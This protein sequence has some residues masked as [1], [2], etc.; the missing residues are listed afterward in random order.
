MSPQALAGGT[1]TLIPVDARR[2]WDAA[3]ADM[4]HAFAHTWD[5]CH[6]MAASSGHATYL[7]SFSADGVRVVCPLAERPIGD[8]VD[9]VT[10]YGF[11]GFVASGD[12]PGFSSHWQRFAAGRGYVCAYLL[13]N[14]VLPSGSLFGDLP[15]RH[16]T[17]FVFDL[18]LSEDELFA[19]LSTNRRRQV[20]RATPD[21]VVT[22]R[23]ELTE[24]FV[25]TYPEFIA[26]RDAAGVYHLAEESMRAL[27]GSPRVLLIGARSG[28]R[29]RAASLFGFTAH[30]GDYLYSASLPGDEQW[31][32]ILIWAAVRELK[33]RGVP[34]LNL[35]GAVSDDDGVA[36]F[37][38]RFGTE[39]V[40]LHNVKQVYRPDVYRALC[41]EAG[42]DPGQTGYFP[43]Y[44]A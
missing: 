13:L 25:A 36:E 29:L 40:P 7:Y 24:F 43:A 12:C 22:D 33:A 17:L 10:P 37:K 14:P 32:A 5:N 15:E 31:S 3:L 1:D 39:E 34:S 27:C 20:R 44:R 19:R 21:A 38:R 26:R 23:E 30:G 4:P 35:G 16:K 41:D 9:L 28:G 6:A 2:A 11:S 8:Y 42:V 18:R